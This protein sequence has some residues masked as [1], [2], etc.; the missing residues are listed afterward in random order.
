MP[1]LPTRTKCSSLGCKN[2][3]A[4]YGGFCI[5]HGGTNTFLH[6]KYNRGQDRKD[7]IQ[8]YQ[9]TQW[10]KLRAAQLSKEPLCAGCIA[11]GIV[12][13]AA[14]VD[15]VFPWSQIGEDAFYRNLYQSLCISCHTVKTGMERRGIYRQYGKP[16]I[17]H[18]KDDYAYVMRINS[19]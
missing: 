9:T 19:L 6:T 18:T 12:T 5:H 17:D 16:N 15:H 3:K 13:P 10:R 8:K 2:R 14:T 11:G 4:K 7:A 1:T